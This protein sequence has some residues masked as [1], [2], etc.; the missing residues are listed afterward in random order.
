MRGGR[1]VFDWLSRIVYPRARLILVI[2]AVVVPLCGI[3]ATGA[4]S[5][6]KVGGFFD[7][8]SPS[9][10]AAALVDRQF[11]GQTNLVFLVEAKNGSVDTPD[12]TAAGT[13]LTARLAAESTLTNVVSYWSTGLP[14]LRSNDGQY[15]VVAAHVSGDENTALKNTQELYDKYV[16]TDGP[17]MV[18]IGGG[19]G[20]NR[21]IF[22]NIMKSLVV[23]EAV[24]VPLT[25]LLLVAAF[26]SLVAALLPL[27]IGLAAIVG[28]FAALT[29]LGSVTDVSLFAANFTA[30]LGLGLGIDYALLIVARFRERLAAG[31]DT[32]TALSH[33]VRT[34]GRTIFFS[35]I[36][37]AAAL[38]TLLVFP[39]YFL[40]SFAYAGIGVVAIA[41]VAALFVVPAI[42]ALLGHRVNAVRL[43]WVKGIRGAD[44]PFWGKLAGMVGRHPVVAAAPVVAALLIAASPLLNVNFGTPD[45]HALKSDVASRVA[46]S[47]ISEKFTGFDAGAMQVVTTRRVDP[48]ALT[49]YAERLSL[50]PGV[51]R[52]DTSAGVFAQGR[53]VQRTS[54]DAQRAGPQAEWL[55]VSTNLE[56]KS[57]AAVDLVHKVRAMAGPAGVPVL[58]GGPD[59]ELIDT[60]DAI[61]D[62]LLLAV[63][64]VLVV[65]FLLLFLFTRSVLQ[66]LRALL[67][68]VLG[69]AA[70]IGVMVWIFQDGHLASFL[71][72]T[73]RPT[74]TAMTVL[75]FCVVFGLSMDYEVFLIG[76]IRELHDQG[77]DSGRAVELGLAK[78][79]RIVSTAAGLLAVSFLALG[80]ASISFVQQFGIGAGLA[81]LIDAVLIRGVLVPASISLMGRAA[82]WAPGPLQKL[83][84]RHVG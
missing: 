20:A 70:T 67:L 16:T 53:L 68:N 6:L 9:S 36:V 40:R 13:A 15:A 45:D 65:T 3:L 75:A 51:S 59:A 77:I 43:P 4:L 18:T 12:L 46:N 54:A 14:A 48:P 21:D 33:T 38:A 10:E 63:G 41:A 44:A 66:P 61:S 47:T 1:P 25:L 73:P 71:G 24:A 32:R 81:I 76:R 83:V 34:A 52:V 19:Q 64:I 2:T 62:R 57:A 35:A 69:L 72:F 37:V 31:D 84:P 5:Q 27:A 82:W 80:T 23:A 17:A 22:D 78:T 49:R 60:K 11:G 58:V 29:V 30:A 74:D 8:A 39:L 79:G 42:L 28:T 7:P 26:G 50:L 55:T 56:K